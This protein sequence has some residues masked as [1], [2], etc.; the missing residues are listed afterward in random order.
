ME[1]SNAS[2]KTRR[3]HIETT[4]VNVS[5]W[6]KNRKTVRECSFETHLRDILSLCRVSSSSLFKRYVHRVRKKK[7]YRRTGTSPET[8][9]ARTIVD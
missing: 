7:L 2:I 3:N 9:A 6:F 1:R 8:A 4:L 5:I